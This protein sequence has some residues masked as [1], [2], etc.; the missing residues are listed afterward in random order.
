MLEI[1]L[2]FKVLIELNL[3]LFWIDIGKLVDKFKVEGSKGDVVD[4]V[5][6]EVVDVL[7]FSVVSL[8]SSKDIVL[9]GFG[10]IGCLV[11]RILIEKVGGGVVLCLCV[12]VVCNGGVVND[13][14]KCV[15]FLC[16]DLVYG[17][18]CGI[19]LVDEEN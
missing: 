18:F 9:Y 7:D 16:C 13:L 6:V 2:V 8:V 3:G 1:F 17:L 5:C 15:S 14:V 19:I 10:R 11:V 4:F 12:I